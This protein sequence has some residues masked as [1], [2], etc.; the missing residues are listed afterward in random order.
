MQATLSEHSF[1]VTDAVGRIGG[2]GGVGFDGH[3]GD[4]HERLVLMARLSLG[5]HVAIAAQQENAL[6]GLTKCLDVFDSE[7]RVDV[8]SSSVSSK[9]QKNR[10]EVMW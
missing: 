2:M 1:L 7:S 9:R 8:M 3:G 4:G 5:Q 10:S 6:P